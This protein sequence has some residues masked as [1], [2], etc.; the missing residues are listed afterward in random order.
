VAGVSLDWIR[1]LR[2]ALN[3]TVRRIAGIYKARPV[4]KK[5]TLMRLNETGLYIKMPP[6]MDN[7]SHTKSAR[8]GIA[9]GSYQR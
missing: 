2:K 3:R 5:E 7:A 4:V 6:L 8:H 1:S 9:K